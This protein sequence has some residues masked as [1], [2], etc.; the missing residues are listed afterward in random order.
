VTSFE[1]NVGGKNSAS[2]N[3]H[4]KDFSFVITAII[5]PLSLPFLRFASLTTVPNSFSSGL[6]PPEC[7][8]LLNGDEDHEKF[9]AYWA[10]YGDEKGGP[11]ALDVC[12][13]HGEK[14]FCIRSCNDKRIEAK[15]ESV[16]PP[17]ELLPADVRYDLWAFANMIYNF[18]TGLSLFPVDCDNNLSPGTIESLYEWNDEKKEEILMRSV[19]DPLC[20]NLLITMLSKD[21]GDRYGSMDEVL[22]HP[23]FDVDVKEEIIQE[24]KNTMAMRQSI[25]DERLKTEKDLVYG[26]NF[27]LNRLGFVSQRLV[28]RSVS[29]VLHSVFGC[30][31]HVPKSFIILPENELGVGEWLRALD[32]V[33]SLMAQTVKDGERKGGDRGGGEVGKEIDE[34]E[35]DGLKLSTP[36]SSTTAFTSIRNE[37][38]IALKHYGETRFN[39][40]WVDEV[41]GDALRRPEDKT[42]TCSF[43]NA[44]RFA[45]L[46][47]AGLRI[48]KRNFG[49]E[50]LARNL[51]VEIDS[52]PKCLNREDDTGKR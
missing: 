24:V 25:I 6:C 9:D 31:F 1:R 41:T 19:K 27:E 39:L 40:L 43:L 20:Q 8:Y 10:D 7:V 15:D 46:M 33:V 50:A 3:F 4:T 45:P 2:S 36:V 26:K 49:L 16:R 34:K 17:Y 22:Q 5:H 11:P 47:L 13:S 42:I 21:V 35:A 52:L 51:K 14:L 12:G 30:D 38:L 48:Y 29:S 32:G 28:D 44:L 23:F 18:V 37:L